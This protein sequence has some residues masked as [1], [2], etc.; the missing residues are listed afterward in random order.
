[1][2][3]NRLLKDAINSRSIRTT[4]IRF[5]H[6]PS[7]NDENNDKTRGSKSVDKTD[8][9]NDQVN[10]LYLNIYR[11]T[12]DTF[13]PINFDCDFFYSFVFFFLIES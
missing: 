8:D 10:C 2:Y 11:N 13:S 5:S 1:M 3:P 9:V 12:F 4:Y 7:S 6:D